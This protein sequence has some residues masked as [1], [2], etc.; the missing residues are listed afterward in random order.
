M[1]GDAAHASQK[2]LRK[3]ARIAYSRKKRR[4]EDGGESAAGVRLGHGGG[5]VGRGVMGPGAPVH[6]QAV[7]P[8]VEHGV[9]AHQLAPA[10]PTL[11][12]GPD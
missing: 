12:F 10:Q 8:A 6:E 7:G 4:G 11:E 9:E 2:P 1:R 5:E 3:S